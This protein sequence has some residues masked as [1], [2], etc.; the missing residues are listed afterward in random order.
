MADFFI[1]YTAH[2]RE[3]A[4]WI[5]YVLEE[6][7]FSIFLQ[8]WDFGPGSNFVL[9]MQ[10]GAAE[11]D[12]TIM[13]LSPE[14]LQSPFARS[15][16]AAALASD[17]EGAA[18]K[19]VPVRVRCCQPAGLLKSVVYIDLVDQDEAKARERLVEGVSGKRAKPTKRP[20][21]PGHGRP[22]PK[23]FPGPESVSS[24][25]PRSPSAYM[26][27]LRRAPSDIDKRRFMRNAFEVIKGHFEGGLQALTQQNDDAESD[28]H[29]NTATEFTAEVFLN[30][31]SVCRCRVWLGTQIGSNGIAYL[32]GHT[33][34]NGYNEM[35]SATVEG[36]DLFLAALGSAFSHLEGS[37][38]L[39]RLTPDEA[40]DYLWRRFVSRL[41]R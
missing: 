35:L 16:W 33:F 20:S 25:P 28:F 12:R 18:R 39:K 34:G 40:A 21:F 19:L 6:E 36:G 30:G 1:S 10:K 8:A 9:E 26:P 17:P 3:W 14:Y 41:E 15:E 23:S 22:M 37:Y 5:G 27:K 38:D 13:I 4:E 7:G 2:D 11:S 32:E 31:K 24:A 29:V